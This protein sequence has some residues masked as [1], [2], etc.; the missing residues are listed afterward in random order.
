MTEDLFFTAEELMKGL[1]RFSMRT[2]QAE[3][4]RLFFPGHPDD[5]YL[6]GRWVQFRDSPLAA[7][8]N[9][10]RTKQEIFEFHL[11]RHTS[12]E[13]KAEKKKVSR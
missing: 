8:C 4:T 6:R 3:F 10:D 5:A 9:M 7:W 11:D 2:N 13:L 12:D 1:R